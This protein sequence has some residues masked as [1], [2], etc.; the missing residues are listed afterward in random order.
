MSDLQQ[1]SNLTPA[2]PQMVEE[3]QKPGVE[4]TEFAEESPDGLL[5]FQIIRLPS[6]V[7]A[8]QSRRTRIFS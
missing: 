8:I 4:I 2:T 6:Q 1:T 3:L 5:Y 7:L